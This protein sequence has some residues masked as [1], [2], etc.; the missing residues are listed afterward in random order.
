MNKTIKKIIIREGFVILFCLVFFDSIIIL[1]KD[2]WN[3]LI[4]FIPYNKLSYLLM[5]VPLDESEYLPPGT[6]EGFSYQ[7]LHFSLVYGL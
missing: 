5:N 4:H 1:L 6:Q 2:L 7:L 3:Y